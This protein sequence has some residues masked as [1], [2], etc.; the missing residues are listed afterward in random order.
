MMLYGV[1]M[2]VV[3][4][5][6]FRRGGWEERLCASGGVV[7]SYLTPLLMSSYE[8]MYRHL[9]VEVMFID[10]GYLLLMVSIALG[11][12]KFW[13]MWVVAMI[14]QTVLAHLLAF[15]PYNI[16]LV[17]RE[18]TVFWSYP[19]WIALA[20]AIRQHSLARRRAAAHI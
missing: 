15:M 9:E 20:F 14:G 19:K 17:Y 3:T 7:A 18:A 10:I 13:P 11:S 4:V 12:R 2:W 16:P 5:Y 6:A 8:S 1:L